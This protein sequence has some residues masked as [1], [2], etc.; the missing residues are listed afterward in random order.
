M[1]NSKLTQLFQKFASK[2]TYRQSVMLAAVVC[3]LLA[4]LIIFYPMGGTKVAK[5]DAPPP[6]PKVEMVKVITAAADIPARTFIKED[7]LKAVEVEKNLAP[8]DAVTEIN[9]LV[10]KPASVNIMKDDIITD[11]KFYKDIKMAGFSGMIPP[12]CRAITVPISDVTAVAGF[13]KPG[14]YVDI[15][16]VDSDEDTKATSGEIVLQNVLLLAINKTGGK[17]EQNTAS[18]KKE[19]QQQDA[20][21]KEEDGKEEKGK[22]GDKKKQA[23]PDD[24]SVRA[25]E[26]NMNMATFALSPE[27]ALELAARSQRGKLYLALRPFKPTDMIVM[28]TEY[29]EA[30]KVAASAP[31]APAQEPSRVERQVVVVHQT[32][33][34]EVTPPAPAP[35]MDTVEVIKGTEKST[36]GVK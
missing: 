5:K 14:D 31:A 16:L 23:K 7:M 35:V 33:P 17:T 6:Q 36:V 24:G 18:E 3:I 19:Q 30:G 27:E 25:S 1:K 4:V 11:K 22:K 10:G 32:P 20:D 21:K 15:M 29:K 13:L 2:L 26:E 9:T 8:S 12:D 28:N 34:V